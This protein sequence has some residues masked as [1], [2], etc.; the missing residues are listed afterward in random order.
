MSEGAAAKKPIVVCVPWIKAN[1]R[2]MEHFTEWYAMNMVPHNLKRVRLFW[3]ALHQA[4][5]RA[6]EIARKV[7]A[8]HVLFTEDDQ[9]GYPVDGLDTLLAADRDVIGFKSYFKKYPYLSMA[10]RQID[11]EMSLIGKVP[12]FHQIEG[13]G[14][15]DEIQE[16]DLLSWAFTLVK[17]EVFDKMDEAGLDPFRQWGPN[18][19]DSFFCEY[20]KRLGIKKYV[21]FGA[22]IGHG[23][24]GPWEI[25]HYRRLHESMNAMRRTQKAQIILEDDYGQT[26]GQAEYLPEAAR[27][28][29]K[30]QEGAHEMDES[31][32][33]YSLPGDGNGRVVNHESEEDRRE[34]ALLHAEQGG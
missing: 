34:V 6:L 26:Y 15:G 27:A 14:H 2:H 10:F 19:T 28:I 31:R 22:T 30:H 11:K 12:N 23:D 3:K 9:W 1:P 5:G 29:A 16:V 7:G 21:H 20:C 32:G 13:I 8:S 4:Q 18:P 33:A 25:M 24:V 17:M